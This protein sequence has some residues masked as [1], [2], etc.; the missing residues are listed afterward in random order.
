MKQIQGATNASLYLFSPGKLSQMQFRESSAVDASILIMWPYTSHV[1]SLS[2]VNMADNS[3][4][5]SSSMS[6]LD[7]SDFEASMEDEDNERVYEP[8]GEIRPWDLNRQDEPKIERESQ[9]RI[10]RPCAAAASIK[11]ARIVSAF[12]LVNKESENQSLIKCRSDQVKKTKCA[13][14]WIPW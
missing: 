5:E 1:C 4:S 2:K 7:N 10:M 13:D 12:T 8:V 11:I 6:R 14:S 9:K 3:S